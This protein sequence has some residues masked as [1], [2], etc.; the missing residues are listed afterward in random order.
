MPWGR[1]AGTIGDKRKNAHTNV[2]SIEAWEEGS[3]RSA[4][5]GA[6]LFGWSFKGLSGKSKG[7]ANIKRGGGSRRLSNRETKLRVFMSEGRRIL[8]GRRK[9]TWRSKDRQL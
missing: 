3:R 9:K 5:K 8:W 6:Y 7:K 1:S 4:G 2:L